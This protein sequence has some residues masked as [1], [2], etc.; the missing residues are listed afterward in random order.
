MCVR[1]VRR[2]TG[3]EAGA[4]PVEPHRDRDGRVCECNAVNVQHRIEG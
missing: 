2:T 3:A 1:S 4:A